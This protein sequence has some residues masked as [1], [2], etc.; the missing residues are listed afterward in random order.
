MTPLE[1]AVIA[2]ARRW[3]STQIAWDRREVNGRDALYEARLALCMALGELDRAE[4][5]TRDE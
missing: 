3:K 2:A 1:A 4:E 5:V